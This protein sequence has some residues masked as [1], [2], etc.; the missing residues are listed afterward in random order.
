MCLSQT[1]ST[2]ITFLWILAYTHRI[3]KQNDRFVSYFFSFF[4]LLS[5]VKV[6][7][8][9]NKNK[10]ERFLVKG[11]FAIFYGSKMNLFCS[12][13]SSSM[14]NTSSFLNGVL[15]FIVQLRSIDCKEHAPTWNFCQ[16]MFLQ[17]LSF[18][19]CITNKE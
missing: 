6:C 13:R 10:N 12:V 16:W 8:D 1:Y 2:K 11:I 7:I 9:Y 4:F 3:Q 5:C 18:F 14:D 17:I 19:F 15:G